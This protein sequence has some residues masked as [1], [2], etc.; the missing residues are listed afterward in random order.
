MRD[1]TT[2]VKP[3]G[4]LGRHPGGFDHLLEGVGVADGQVRK[5]LAIESDALLVQPGDGRE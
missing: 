4:A 3:I 2:G 5:D 1:F